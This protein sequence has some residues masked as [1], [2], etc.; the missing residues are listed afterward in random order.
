ML[1]RMTAAEFSPRR[2]NTALFRLTATLLLDGSGRRHGRSVDPDVLLAHEPWQNAAEAHT[3]AILYTI[4]FTAYTI[5]IVSSHWQLSPLVSVAIAPIAVVVTSI[6]VNL[7]MYLVSLAIYP[8][9]R[10]LNLQ[11]PGAGWVSDAHATLVLALSVAMLFHD[12]W[13]RNVAAAWLSL[14]VVNGIAAIVLRLIRKQVDEVDAS[15][16]TTP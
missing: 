5:A 1:R 3:L 2:L 6:A 14:A 4:L 9:R 15:F 16:V 13:A 11:H 7:S 10:I 12:T 8:I